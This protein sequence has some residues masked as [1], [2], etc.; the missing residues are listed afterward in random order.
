MF[1]I[2]DSQFLLFDRPVTYYAVMPVVAAVLI[3]GASCFYSYKRKYDTSFIFRL[4]SITCFPV[5]VGH[6]FLSYIP[7]FLLP[8]SL[9]FSFIAVPA[10]YVLIGRI[11]GK[12]EGMLQIGIFSCTLYLSLSKLGCFLTGCCFGK[13]Y[14]GIFSVTYS[15]DSMCRLSET[16]LFPVQLLTSVLLAAVFA[17]ML[18][19]FMKKSDTLTAILLGSAA[20]FIYY[21]CIQLC[22]RSANQMILNGMDFS[23][24]IAALALA[25]VAV[26]G[27]IIIN[28]I[29]S[30][31]YETKNHQVDT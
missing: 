17:V 12:K 27:I 26:C 18:I 24:I 29:R 5:A 23:L 8:F 16:A 13:S 14:D 2:E 25:V 15:A 20:I 10:A 31:N 11:F 19:T 4:S 21:S 30:E 28:K 1:Y 7:D 6:L 9:L 22:D 3:I